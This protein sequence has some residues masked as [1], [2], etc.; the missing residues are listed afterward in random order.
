MFNK[1]D[2]LTPYENRK[3]CNGIKIPQG[4]QVE[5]LE[6]GYKFGWDTK[7]SVPVKIIS[8]H[9]SN[10]CGIISKARVQ[11][12][13]KEYRMNSSYGG[14]FCKGDTL[15]I[16]ADA[17]KRISTAGQS[18]DATP[19]VTIDTGKSSVAIKNIKPHVLMCLL[20]K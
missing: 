19:H 20:S 1:G 6:K 17:F 13:G 7:I 12:N 8:D 18:L 4:L 10:V 5:V 14:K 9:S 2:I 11:F 16:F 15:I 3:T